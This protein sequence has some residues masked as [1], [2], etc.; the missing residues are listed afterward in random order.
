MNETHYENKYSTHYRRRLTC[1]FLGQVEHQ[2]FTR[3]LVTGRT[4]ISER[5]GRRFQ[6]VRED[7]GGKLLITRGSQ[8]PFRYTGFRKGHV[9][10]QS[11]LHS[12]FYLTCPCSPVLQ[13]H[14]DVHVTSVHDR[15]DLCWSVLK[16]RVSAF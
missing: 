10:S 1:R 15:C 11:A 14:F 2:R 7:F 5:R 16:G 8:P 9:F 12:A 4:R 13:A 6:K 3:V